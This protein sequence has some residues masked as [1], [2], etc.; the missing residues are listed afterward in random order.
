MQRHWTGLTYS[1]LQILQSYHHFDDLNKNGRFRSVAN[2]NR[3]KTSQ[4][5]DKTIKEKLNAVKLLQR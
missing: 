5:D 4:I 1:H 3:H 2:V